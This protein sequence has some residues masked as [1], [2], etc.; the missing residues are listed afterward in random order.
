MFPFFNRAR[1]AF[2]LAFALLASI[3]VRIETMIET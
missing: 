1:A 2:P 3:L